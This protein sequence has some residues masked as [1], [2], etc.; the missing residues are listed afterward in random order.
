MIDLEVL[1]DIPP[2]EWPEDTG[3]VLL[4]ILLDDQASEADRVL[5]AELAGDY[6]VINDELADALLSNLAN[7]NRSEEVRGRAAI[8]LGPVL[9]QGY[10]EEF[11]DP[12]AVPI[13]QHTF[14]RIQASLR[15]LYAV[16]DVPKE[17]RR[18]ILEAS[19]RAPLDWHRDAVRA[20]YASDDE[21]WRVT[22]V[23]CMRFIRGFDAQILE[24]LNSRNESIHYEAVI[25]AGNSELIEAWPHI[26]ALVT[27]KQTEKPLLLAAIEAA[28]NIR[29]GEAAGILLGL[30][31]SPDE[32]I[33][34]AARDALVFGGSAWAEDDE[35]EEEDDDD[36]V[37]DDDERTR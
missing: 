35:Y 31:D 36:F 7:R 3:V 10:V 30:T 21:A 19:V 34:E 2:W 29:P 22:A 33:A 4:G 14:H 37:D 27:S 5:A 6:T 13:T 32:D 23:F 25:A 20:A 18:S 16:A 8:S 28:A 1:Q 11:E 26:A 15:E 9:E 17:V 24:A 12:D